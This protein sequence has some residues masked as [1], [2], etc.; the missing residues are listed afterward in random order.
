VLG[1]VIDTL[2]SIARRQSVALAREI[3]LE[4][5]IEVG[6]FF[7]LLARAPQLREYPIWDDATAEMVAVPSLVSA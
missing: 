7:D 6:P 2:R 1:D 4:P 5:A 3:G